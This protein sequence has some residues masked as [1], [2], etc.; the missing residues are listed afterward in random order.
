MIA[1]VPIITPA[2]I[3][4]TAEEDNPLLA[5]CAEEVTVTVAVRVDDETA[6]EVAPGFVGG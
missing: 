1:I 2:T 5:P 4:P 3:P 6:R